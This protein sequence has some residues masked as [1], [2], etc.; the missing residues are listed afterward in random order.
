MG[1]FTAMPLKIGLL[2]VLFLAV[3]VVYWLLNTF[4][5]P[6]PPYPPGP[7][8]YPIVGSLFDIN[9]ERPWITYGKWAQQYGK[10]K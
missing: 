1:L 2:F 10:S 9:S 5:K 4:F 7:K 8:G 6:K 3:A